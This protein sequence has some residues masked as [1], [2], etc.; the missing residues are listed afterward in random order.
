V[1]E[2]A[3]YDDYQTEGGSLA[4]ALNDQ[5][6]SALWKWSDVVCKSGL[7]PESLRG[8]A[9]DVFLT[10]MT[11]LDFGF[12]PTQAFNLV[13][14]VKGR[15]SLSAEGMRARLFQLG[16]EFE[17]VESSADKCVVRGRRAGAE[18]WHEAEFTGE[19]A[20]K[21]G[22]SGQNWTAYREDMLFA[23]ATTRLCKRYFPDVTNGLPSSEELF[24]LPVERRERPTLAA[25]ATERGGEPEQPATDPEAL[26]A[27]VLEIEAE[28]TANGEE[29]PATEPTDDGEADPC[30]LCSAPRSTRRSLGSRRRRRH[31]RTRRA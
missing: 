21:A 28:H 6:S 27:Q 9:N 12:K 16:H 17:V 15:P 31:P 1:T 11:G 8:K 18:K 26:R 20:K 24:D 22:L 10:V 14:I 29:P 23:R 13:Y 5:A 30:R 2:L 7:V 25:V 19:Q 3:K 4:V